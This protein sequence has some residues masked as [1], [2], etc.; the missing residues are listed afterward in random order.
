MKQAKLPFVLS[1]AVL[2]AGSLS[3]GQLGSLTVSAQQG[4]ST[5]QPE[6]T[7]KEVDG[8][9]L[10]TAVFNTPNGKISVN[11]PDDMAA[12]DTISGTVVAEATGNTPEEKAKNE[13]EISGYVVEVAKAEEVPPVEVAQKVEK[14]KKKKAPVCTKDKPD[15]TCLIPPAIGAI[16]LILRAPNGKKVCE[17]PMTCLPTPPPQSCPPGECCMPTVGS[18]GRPVAIKGPCDGKFANTNVKIGGETAK[19]LAESPRQQIVK[20]PKNVV[21]PTTIERKEGNSVA[22]GKFTNL[23]VKLAAAKTGLKK[24]ESTTITVT[25]EGLEGISTPVNLHIVNRAE[26]VIEMDGGNDQKIRLN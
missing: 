24:G 5:A 15:F 4:A 17:T 8:G 19:P 25:V 21:G 18:C 16:S 26:D 2:L 7:A 13:D 14:P 1:A 20:S 12:E 11:L 23:K 3:F 9:G 22:T 6:V 10:K